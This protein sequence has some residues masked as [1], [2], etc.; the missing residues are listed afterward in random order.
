[1]LSGFCCL[2]DVVVGWWDGSSSCSSITQVDDPPLLEAW[3]AM[4]EEIGSLYMLEMGS[5]LYQCTEKSVLLLRR[6]LIRIAT[7]KAKKRDTVKTEDALKF[8][9]RVG[10]TMHEIE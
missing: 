5:R 4:R 6:C 9:L 10:T 8:N 1:M 3:R 7:T 2:G